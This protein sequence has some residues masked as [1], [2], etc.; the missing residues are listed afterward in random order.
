MRKAIRC[1]RCRGGA[2]PAEGMLCKGCLLYLGPEASEQWVARWWRERPAPE[3][4]RA[5]RDGRLPRSRPVNH[6]D[7][8]R[9]RRCGEAFWTPFGGLNPGPLCGPCADIEAQ[10]AAERWRQLTARQRLLHYARSVLI[11]VCALICV[12]AMVGFEAYFGG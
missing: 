4:V 2:V 11:F 12:V 3:Y 8:K 9:C 6:D 10:I 7:V 5:R 1:P